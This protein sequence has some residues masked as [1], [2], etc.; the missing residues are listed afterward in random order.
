M[1]FIAASVRVF[2]ALIRS[3]IR[4][5]SDVGDILDVADLPA[6]RWAEYKLFTKPLNALKTTFPKWLETN[7]P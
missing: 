7:P 5:G 1:F 2:S 6:K 3:T 4:P